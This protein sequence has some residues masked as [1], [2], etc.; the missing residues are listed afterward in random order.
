MSTRRFTDA[1]DPASD[2][3]IGPYTAS[4]IAFHGSTATSQRVSSKLSAGL[5]LFTVTGA[6]VIASSA[7]TLSG[8][9]SFTTT[10]LIDLWDAVAELRNMLA[11]KGLHKGGA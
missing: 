5:S 10:Q 3:V 7:V 2:R 4:K 6:S 1:L 8:L 9:Y 11:E